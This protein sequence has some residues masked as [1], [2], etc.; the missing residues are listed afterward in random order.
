MSNNDNN[1]FA[2][3]S[4]D[5]M[6]DIQNQMN[7]LTQE[8]QDQIAQMTDKVDGATLLLTGPPLISQPAYS[9]S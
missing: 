5:Q 2:E 8:E 7:E 1:M 4:Y 9:P 6:R 3:L